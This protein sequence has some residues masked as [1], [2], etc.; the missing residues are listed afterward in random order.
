MAGAPPPAFPPAAGPAPGMAAWASGAGAAALARVWA[1]AG[2]LD[3]G[4]GAE[5]LRASQSQGELRAGSPAGGQSDIVPVDT[6]FVYPWAGAAAGDYSAD[7]R[8]A[9]GRRPLLEGREGACPELASPT[10]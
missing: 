8:L 9:W 1:V 7:R 3:T 6:I 5:K 2:T 10:S 4:A